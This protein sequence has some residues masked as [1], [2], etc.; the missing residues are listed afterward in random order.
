MRHPPAVFKAR[1][2]DDDPMQ[3]SNDTQQHSG[4]E[5]QARDSRPQRSAATGSTDE[6]IGRPANWR[7]GRYQRSG[8]PVDQSVNQPS[9]TDDE[10]HDTVGTQTP[11]ASSRAN[12][13]KPLPPEQQKPVTLR[14][15]DP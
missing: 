9:Q 2:A 12:R 5:P 15:Y 4:D 1:A 10:P 14:D 6:S 11:P 13:P 7:E 3:H 8:A